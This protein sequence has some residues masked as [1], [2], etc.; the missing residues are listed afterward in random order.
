MKNASCSLRN[1]QVYKVSQ[2][3]DFLAGDFIN[4]K[5]IISDIIFLNPSHTFIPNQEDPESHK[6]FSLKRHLKHDLPSL[7]AKSF[8][9]SKKVALRLPGYTN[10]DEL[11]EVFHLALKEY[12]M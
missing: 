3:I 10:L 6:D 12:A 11:A 1:S 8:S 2:K 7:I 9:V 4:M 5:N